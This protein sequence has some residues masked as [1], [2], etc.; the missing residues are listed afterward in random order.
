MW[1]ALGNIPNPLEG[2]G[3]EGF[4]ALVEYLIIRKVGRKLGICQKMI[5]KIQIAFG[6][7]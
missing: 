7:T 4:T 2:Y 6:N 1:E 3:S 5:V